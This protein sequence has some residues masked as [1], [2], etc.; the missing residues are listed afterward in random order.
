MCKD[1][2]DVRLF[3]KECA[4]LNKDDVMNI[5]MKSVE[6]KSSLVNLTY[7]CFIVQF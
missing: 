6:T 3:V 4:I 1:M 2:I 7:M 5:L